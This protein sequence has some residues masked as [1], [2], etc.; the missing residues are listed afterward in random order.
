MAPPDPTRRASQSRAGNDPATPSASV[1]SVASAQDRLVSAWGQMGSAWG[2]SR[3][4]AE[5]H[6]LLFIT[7]SDMCADDVM[8]RLQISRGNVSMS[9]RALLEW[10]VIER[11]IVPGERKEYYRALDDV[12]AM[13]RAIIRQRMQREVAPVLAMLYEI[14]DLTEA[15]A[16]AGRIRRSGH[17]ESDTPASP[18]VVRE[19]NR[20][21]DELLQFFETL[22]QLSASFTAPEDGRGLQAAANALAQPASAVGTGAEP[23]PNARSNGPTSPNARQAKRRS[24]PTRGRP[25]AA[26]ASGG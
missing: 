3:T 6:A 22:S 18:A 16:Q 8:D 1:Q 7:G 19:H 12:W 5:V 9:L 26:G 21:M 14:R 24:T 25:P 23:T 13:F 20:R 15:S 2:I 17:S 10:G 4:M 11:L